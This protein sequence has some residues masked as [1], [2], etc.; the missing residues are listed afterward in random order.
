[1]DME[2]LEEQSKAF[3][4]CSMELI[5]LE[6]TKA[7]SP[8]RD[9]QE[10]IT[11]AAISSLNGI[12]RWIEN[13]LSTN[14]QEEWLVEL[15]QEV[16]TRQMDARLVETLLEQ[17]EPVVDLMYYKIACIMGRWHSYWVPTTTNFIY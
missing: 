3:K 7:K 6:I 10:E 4:R 14:H 15:A 17:M 5:D 2:S 9:H 11:K 16:E 13:V 8:R 1:M 12:T